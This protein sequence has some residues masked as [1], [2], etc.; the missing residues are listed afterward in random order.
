MEDNSWR[1][2]ELNWALESANNTIENDFKNPPKP[3]VRCVIFGHRWYTHILISHM[4]QGF[5]TYRTICNRCK[6]N[7]DVLEG[8]K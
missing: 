4:T 2:T 1:K 8:T 7:Q 5:N 3:K 6:I